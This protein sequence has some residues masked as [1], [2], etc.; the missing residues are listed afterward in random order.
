VPLL[1]IYL[2]E[3]QLPLYSTS[4]FIEDCT[5]NRKMTVL[6]MKRPIYVYVLSPTKCMSKSA[7][8]FTTR[9]TI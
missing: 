8:L 4:R 5:V 7:R 9:I 2:V 1:G 6:E 3:Q